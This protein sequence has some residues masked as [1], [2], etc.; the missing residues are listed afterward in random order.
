MRFRISKLSI[1]FI[2]ISVVL[3]VII[4][5]KYAAIQD[6]N[7]NESR[8]IYI[9]TELLCE[10]S[11]S[12]KK[13]AYFDL[14]N[15]IVNFIQSKKEEKDISDVSIYLRDLKDGPTLGINEHSYFVPASLLK[16]PVLLT[17]LSLAEDEPELL[18]KKLQYKIIKELD[19]NQRIPAKY[20]IEENT[21][22]TISDLLK[23]MI[24]YSDNKAYYILVQY[25]DQSYSDRNP[26][27][28]IMGDLGIL[29]PKNFSDETITVKLYASIFF[30]LYNATFLREKENSE[31]ALTLLSDT[32]YKDGIVAGV[33]NGINVAH[34]FGERYF[35]RDL[36]QLHDCGI[37]YY[38]NNPYLICIMTRGEDFEK[39]PNIIS[40][41]SKMVYEEFNSRKI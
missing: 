14:K 7:C 18:E 8:F 17:Y 15:K 20:S 1:L 21:P 38:P 9:N 6:K 28:E 13:H 27:L 10:D 3:G 34:K 25:L 5:G 11:Y 24:S 2:L 23:Y 37:V 33:P 16:V 31:K 41:I 30:Q 39:L 32:D 26:L 19:T 4:G 40:T 12:I 29:D 22:Y 36:K 35:A